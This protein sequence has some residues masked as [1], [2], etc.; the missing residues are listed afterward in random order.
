[1]IETINQRI[2][3][4]RKEANLKQAGFADLIGV[5]R[6]TVS[7]L[8]KDGNTIVDQNKRIICDKFH[9]SMHWLETGEGNMYAPDSQKDIFDSMRDELN[10]S[11]VEGKILRGYFELDDHSRKAVTDFIVNI[12]RST[13]KEPI[14]ENETDEDDNDLELKHRQEIIAAEFE[15]E[16]KGKMSLASTGTNGHIKRA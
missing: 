14:P 5:K 10:L 9:V 16:K 11:D 12:G 4:V 13:A 6:V 2:R 15:A 8:E 1:V 3:I 7:W